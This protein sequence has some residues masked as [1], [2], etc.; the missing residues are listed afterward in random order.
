MEPSLSAGN[1]FPAITSKVKKLFGKNSSTIIGKPTICSGIEMETL[2]LFVCFY[3]LFAFYIE[4]ERRGTQSS[5]QQ[6]F[7][8]A[9]SA[10]SWRCN[11]QTSDTR[12]HQTRSEV[13]PRTWQESGTLRERKQRRDWG[14]RKGWERGCR[15]IITACISL[16]F[17]FDLVYTS[18]LV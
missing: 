10:G 11:R 12:W 2:T 4:A 7:V 18:N 17:C 5:S 14:E 16:L 6:G 3:F 13:D 1:W 15:G 9:S 8:S